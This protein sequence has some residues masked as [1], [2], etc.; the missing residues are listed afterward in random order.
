VVLA[1]VVP[2]TAFFLITGADYYFQH[3][4]HIGLVGLQESLACTPS[5]TGSRCLREILRKYNRFVPP[6]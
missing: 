5:T 1:G 4:L 6:R 2:V 3:L